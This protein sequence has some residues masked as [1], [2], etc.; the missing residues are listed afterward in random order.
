MNHHASNANYI[1]FFPVPSV[2]PLHPCHTIYVLASSLFV[3]CHVELKVLRLAV[4]PC[5]AVEV[6]T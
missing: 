6:T 1:T 4:G 5:M 3:N 2:F